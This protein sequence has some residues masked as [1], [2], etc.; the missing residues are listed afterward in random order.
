MSHTHEF[1]CKVCGAHLDS[2]QE[3]DQHN[4]QHLQVSEPGNRATGDSPYQGSS[5]QASSGSQSGRQ[6]RSGSQASSGMS[7]SSS[8]RPSSRR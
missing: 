2:R 5:R 8:G 4:S 7:E 1:D 6:A 3:L